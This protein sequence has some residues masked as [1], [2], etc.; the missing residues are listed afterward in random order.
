MVYSLRNTMLALTCILSMQIAAHPTFNPKNT[1]IFFDLHDVVLKVDKKERFK[2]A[3]KN[4]GTSLKL[5]FNKVSRKNCANGEEY[6]LLLKKKGYAKEA[7]LVRKMSAAYKVNKDVLCIIKTLQAKGYTVNM[8]S[9][10]GAQHLEDLI[11][12]GHIKGHEKR[13][14]RMK[15]RSAIES[16]DDLVFVDYE[17]DRVIAKP[18][19]AYFELL[20]DNCGRDKHA[21]FV[22]DSR[23]NVHAAQRSGLH[24]IR[25][26]S[27]KQLK[28]DL[29]K[30]G[31][32]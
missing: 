2:L 20:R 1:T 21:I 4:L 11:N 18:S 19:R 26:T 27:A 14:K 30:F 32:L 9:N 15:V 22:D 13:K 29:Q 16:F 6:A 24:G 12:P 17:T 3:L 25:F 28:K 23:T 7:K 10:I 8:A 5:A 31:I